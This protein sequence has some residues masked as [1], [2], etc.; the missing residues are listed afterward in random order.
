V[1]KAE[2]YRV[3]MERENRYL[4]GGNIWWVNH[5][6]TVS[7]S[8]PMNLQRVKDLAQN[9]YQKPTPY[10]GIISVIL[11]HPGEGT[12]DL[13]VKGGNLLRI[14]PEELTHAFILGINMSL[15]EGAPDEVIQEWVKHSKSV[16]FSFHEASCMQDVYWMS[17][18]LREALTSDNNAVQRT[19]RQRACEVA[20][21]RS[22]LLKEAGPQTLEMLAA[23]IA[24]RG[25]LATES[26]KMDSSYVQLCMAVYEKIC[27]NKVICA[28][29]QELEERHGLK[30][31]LN[32]MTKLARLASACESTELRQWVC[33]GLLDAI[34]TRQLANSNVTRDFLVGTG[35]RDNKVSF[36]QLISFKWKV[37]QHI[38]TVECPK[39]MFNA[40][41]IR[42]ITEATANYHVFRQ[43]VSPLETAADADTQWTGRLRQSSTLV[44]RIIQA[45]CGTV[46]GC[47][48]P[49]VGYCTLHGP[50]PSGCSPFGER[51]CAL[52]RPLLRGCSPLSWGSGSAP[53]DN[54]GPLEHI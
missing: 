24:S 2:E 42:E 4:C 5:L 16:C 40:E 21:L 47:S 26:E 35:K 17:F 1:F 28:V 15:E 11:E 7:P 43:R 23:T 45:Q 9:F 31:C 34:K 10:Q 54:V 48:P 27:Q 3:A 19:A 33:E 14:S 53:A 41:E 25:R 49:S 12:G 39:E 20:E 18:N 36:V 8:V 22:T 37:R 44:L 32:S 51:D 38:L 52:L 46:R 29:L 30:S 6:R 50:P 13:P